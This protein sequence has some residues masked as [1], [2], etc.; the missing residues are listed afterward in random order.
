MDD[1]LRAMLVEQ[2]ELFQNSL[3]QQRDMSNA[4]LDGIKHPWRHTVENIKEAV[5]TIRKIGED[6][7]EV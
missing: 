7:E 4:H 2:N 1:I 5:S 3:Q 6:D